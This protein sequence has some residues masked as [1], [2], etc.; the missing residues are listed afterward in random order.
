MRTAAP[1]DTL[2]APD[3]R[4]APW[5]VAER[6][7]P[8]TWSGPLSGAVSVLAVAGLVSLL[9][10]RNSRFF[11]VDDRQ[12]D[13][14]PKLID[15]GRIVRSGHWPW[16]STDLVESS[17]HAIEYQNAIYNPVNVALSVFL[18]GVDDVAFGSFVYFLVHAVVLTAAAAWL[19]RTLGLSAGWT[20]A[21]AVS[22]GF[23]PYTWVWGAGW[24]QAVTSF[25]WFVVAVA[26]AMAFH[27]QP[28]R[29][30]GWAVLLGTYGA[31]TSGWPLA[32]PFLGIVVATLLLARLAL[33]APRR[34]TA[35]LGAWYAGGVIA[36]LVA[37]Y[38]LV[39]S[40]ALATR[41]AGMRNNA[42][43]NVVPLE[44]LLHFAD[45]SYW[46]WFV[47][48]G[49]LARQELPHFYVA[50]F[51]LPVLVLWRRGPFEARTRALLLTAVA[52]VV[53]AA[54]GALGPERVLVF[55]FPTRFL[56]YF[57]FFLLVTAALL[58]ARGSFAFT[59]RRLG[60]LLG[61]VALLTLNSLQADPLGGDRILPLCLALAA[62]VAATWWL[63][64]R[65]H[66][67]AARWR[68]PLADAVIA[69]GTV[70]LLGWLAVLHPEPRGI[71]YGFPSDLRTVEP[72]SLEDYTL[73]YGTYPRTDASAEELRSFYAEYH[74]S[75]TGLMAGTRQV[76]GY[77]PLGNRFFRDRFP[78]DD[79][80][81]FR[82]GGAARFAAFDP[83]TGVTWLELLRVDQVIAL[84]G[85]RADELEDVLGAPWT[86]T[87]EGEWTATYR[88]PTYDLPGLLSYVSPGTAVAAVTE[89]ECGAGPN[90]ECVDVRGGTEE[91]RLVFA[92][93]WF[94]GYSA[95][96]DGEPVEVQRHGDLLVAVDVAPGD[97][98]RLELTYR[99]PR[100]LRLTVL[101]GA[102]LV[103]LGVGS[104]LVPLSTARPRG[105]RRRPAPEGPAAVEA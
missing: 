64:S 85:D 22:V 15:I 41:S 99:S 11:F 28:R 40:F 83:A 73:F 25:T 20:V 42:N 5:P 104:V 93:L 17:G 97:A 1:V 95:T 98:G 24:Y 54:L 38:P 33:R 80:G 48:F 56:Q 34:D 4:G 18:A 12:A 79:Q 90:H 35:W 27:Q 60:V 92:R 72:L 13:A 58:V 49:G 78:M 47:N 57:G 32:I 74:P 62:L 21:F 69:S 52:A 46:G 103:A 29:R 105:R 2:S 65:S 88:G 3:V 100:V 37:L 77:S 102:S 14:V 51:V 63:G 87:S 71:D 96:L 68:G 89:Q 84:L 75:S 36:S 55:R 6:P 66:A 43:F 10:L 81:N 76:N 16:L 67:R 101:A 61:L 86:R 44:G 70:L 19:G 7:R 82:A 91:G 53:L 9:Y 26:A 45:P 30:Y 31:C 59:R 39:A 8:R 23:Q 94:P 50:W